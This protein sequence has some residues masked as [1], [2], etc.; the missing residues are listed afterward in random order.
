MSTA[1]RGKARLADRDTAVALVVAAIVFA[2]YEATRAGSLSG[3]F[4]P[5]VAPPRELA[6]PHLLEYLTRRTGLAGWWHVSSVAAAAAVALSYVT[7]RRLGAA[8]AAAA[9]A[10]L[11]LGFGREFWQQALLPGI[12]PF[13]ALSAALCG[14][15]STRLPRTPSRLWPVVSVVC[16]LLTV[17][18]PHVSALRPIEAA[19][20]IF[21]ELDAVGLALAAT[22][23][24]ALAGGRG[25]FIPVAAGISALT[26]I[27][28]ASSP[29]AALV[30]VYTVLCPLA[31]LGASTLAGWLGSRRPIWL[32]LLPAVPFLGNVRH[33]VPDTDRDARRMLESFAAHVGRCDRI[34]G[35]A[36]RATMPHPDAVPE[37]G[38]GCD[39]LALGEA[40]AALEHLGYRFETVATAEDAAGRTFDLSRLTGRTPCTTLSPTEWT[41]LTPL[42]STGRLGILLTGSAPSDGVLIYAARDRPLDPWRPLSWTAVPPALNT[43]AFRRPDDDPILADSLRAD[44][45][46]P[47]GLESPAS[48]HRIAVTGGATANGGMLM[49]LDFAGVPSVVRARATGRSRVATICEAPRGRS[50]FDVP[51]VTR[52]VIRGGRSFYGAGWDRVVRRDGRDW[53]PLSTAEAEL[54]FQLA[55]PSALELRITAAAAAAGAAIGI[56]VNGTSFEPQPLAAGASEHRWTVPPQAWKRGVNQVFVRGPGG[57]MIAEVVVSRIDQ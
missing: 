4:P 5:D 40:R 34:I 50:L 45:L 21:I 31:A 14:L 22:G 3:L 12:D 52:E 48:I 29:H 30:P 47:A 35:Q 42:T 15:A 44:A 57:L 56:R 18:M 13:L 33:I 8:T 23:F 49:S 53:R 10:A 43:H 27:R 20:W 19:R 25:V 41:D 2:V 16:L 46:E 55:R 9:A 17:G 11:A 24:W 28:G 37:R 38:A 26:L 32:V 36:S 39:V 51:G 1:A 54:L 7:A 6:D